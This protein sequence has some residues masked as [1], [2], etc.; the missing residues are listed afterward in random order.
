MVHE[1]SSLKYFLQ[2][3]VFLLSA[4]WIISIQ[5]AINVSVRGG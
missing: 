3:G 2:F 4:G 5:K 1:M